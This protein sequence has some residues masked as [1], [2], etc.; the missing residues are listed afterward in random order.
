MDREC[1]VEESEVRTGANGSHNVFQVASK[2]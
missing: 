1:Y 2:C